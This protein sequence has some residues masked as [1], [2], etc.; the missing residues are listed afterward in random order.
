M[1]TYIVRRLLLAIP[2]LLLVVA[3]TTVAIRLIPGD[4][5]DVLVGQMDLSGKENREELR[6]QL[7]ASLGLDAPIHVQYLRWWRDLLLHGDLGESI[8]IGGEVRDHIFQRLPVTAEVGILAIIIALLIS[9]PIAIYS[10]IRQD[11]VGD[12]I[13]RSVA[14]LLISVP[15]FW[16]GIMVVVFPSVWWGWS[17]PIINISL[18]DDPIGNLKMYILPAAILGMAINGVNMRLTRTMMLEVVREDYI[19][20]AYSKGLNERIVVIRHALKNA[21][22]PVITV[23]GLNVPVVVG[24]SVIIE[25]IFGLPGMGRLA[26]E[27]AFIRDYPLIV[28]VTL[29]FSVFVLIIILLTD[30]SYALLDPRIRYR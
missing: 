10:A 4:A 28:G 3:L 23:I 19:R 24:G 2:T 1:R 17:P 7:E 18:W 8:F 25:Q 27:A 6:A 22:I 9:F 29:V 14:I 13:A 11:T 16:V 12:Y 30:L 20:T 26:V 5:I 15:S 21:L